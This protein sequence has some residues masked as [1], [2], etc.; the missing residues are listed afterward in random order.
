MGDGIAFA[1]L[2]TQGRFCAAPRL[3]RTFLFKPR[4]EHDSCL[5]SNPGTSTRTCLPGM[6]A[7]DGNRTFRCVLMRWGG[8][9]CM[10]TVRQADSTYC[11]RARLTRD[12]VAH[13]PGLGLQ[14]WRTLRQRNSTVLANTSINTFVMNLQ[15]DTLPNLIQTRSSTSKQDRSWDS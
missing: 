11:N 3:K 12:A 2:S 1:H 13:A 7:R 6:G 15:R 8:Q 4:R 9:I 14:R 5:A 10:Q